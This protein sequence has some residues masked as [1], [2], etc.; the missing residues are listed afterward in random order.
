MFISLLDKVNS[1]NRFNNLLKS[2][3]RVH[4]PGSGLGGVIMLKLA[5]ELIGGRAAGYDFLLLADGL[6]GITT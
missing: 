3:D 4:R 1:L 2:F 5:P 6:E